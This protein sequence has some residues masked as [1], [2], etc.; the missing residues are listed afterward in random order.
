MIPGPMS[1]NPTLP[2]MRLDPLPTIPATLDEMAR[3][4][5]SSRIAGLI[6]SSLTISFAS[7]SLSLS[8]SLEPRLRLHYDSPSCFPELR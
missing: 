6:A 7:L 3:N 5:R 8:L 2:M 1:T 4:E